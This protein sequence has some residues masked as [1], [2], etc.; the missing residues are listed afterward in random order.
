MHIIKVI[1]KVVQ[2]GEK[3]GS[4]NAFQATIQH[5]RIWNLQDG[6][7][8]KREETEGNV[9]ENVQKIKMKRRKEVNEKDDCRLCVLF[10]KNVYST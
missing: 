5:N 6:K 2:F 3:G 4:F 9:D 8:E 1:I 10:V 7:R